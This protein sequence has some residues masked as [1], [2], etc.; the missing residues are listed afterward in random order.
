MGYPTPLEQRRE[1]LRDV[2]RD[3]ADEDGLAQPVPLGDVLDDG[4]VLGLLGLVDEVVFVVPDHLLVRRDGDDLHLVGVHELVGLGRRRAGHAGELVVHPEVVL[5]G[6]GGDGL[7]LFLDLDALFGLDGLVEPLG[8]SPSL[9]H[10][11][12]ELVDDVD[13]P[14]ADDVLVVLVEERL[15]PQ[16]LVQ[17]VDEVGVDVVVEVL[18]AQGLLDL[19]HAALGRGHLLLLLVHLVV[20]TVLE[21]RDY[22]GEAVVDV[23]GALRHARDDERGARLVDQD[24]VDL[25]HDREVEV[26]LHEL[27]CRGRYVVA[28]VVEA[29]L[30]V[31]AVGDVRVVGDLPLVE[32]HAL[33]DEADL[34]AEEG[35]DL[36]H[37]DSRRASPGS[38]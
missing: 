15:G 7:V 28:E 24:G 21:A 5:D 27:V 12:R 16:S 14:V 6:D 2:D 9:Q 33:L 23:G 30:G 25:V 1:A 19:L 36:T 10:T 34:E 29:E 37:P 18:H 20:L 4:L 11:P 3:R 8:V 35:V 32:A 31:G 26:A 13:L 38:R 22:G 17:V